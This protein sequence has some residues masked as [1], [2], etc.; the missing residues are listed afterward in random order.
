MAQPKSAP[1]LEWGEQAAAAQAEADAS[2]Q[3]LITKIRADAGSARTYDACAG[4]EGLRRRERLARDRAIRDLSR[5]GN[6]LKALLPRLSADMRNE[7]E[8][9]LNNASEFIPG[10]RVTPRAA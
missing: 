1:L 6:A 9:V 3:P 7:A 5:N 8:S 10:L 4:I 2:A